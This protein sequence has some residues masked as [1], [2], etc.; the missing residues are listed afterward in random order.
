MRNRCVVPHSILSNIQL[1]IFDVNANQFRPNLAQFVLEREA[2]AEAARWDGVGFHV[3]LNAGRDADFIG[4]T[5]VSTSGSPID[6]RDCKRSLRESP[7]RNAACFE[8]RL[9]Q[10]RNTKSRNPSRGWSRS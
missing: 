2:K 10:S 5:N 6:S 8:T 4:S 1:R 3:N 7:R 9:G